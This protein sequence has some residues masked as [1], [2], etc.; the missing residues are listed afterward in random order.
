MMISSETKSA[1]PEMPVTLLGELI[2]PAYQSTA[3]PYK[4]HRYH[5]VLAVNPHLSLAVDKPT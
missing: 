4:L 5:L 2:R 1:C 3:W